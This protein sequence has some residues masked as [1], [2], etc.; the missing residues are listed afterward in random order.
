MQ[1]H[2]HLGS[3]WSGVPVSVGSI[4]LISPTWWGLQSAKQLKNI[5]MYIL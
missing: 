2:Q 5:V 4:P 3:N 1:H